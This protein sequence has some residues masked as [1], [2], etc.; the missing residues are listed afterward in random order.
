VASLILPDINLLVY[1]HNVDD[2]AFSRT[3]RWLSDLLSGRDRACFSWETI[4]GFV[5]LVTSPVVVKPTLS[6]QQ[7]FS[8]VNIWL[9]APGSVIL[10]KTPR[11]FA[12]LEEVAI[13]ANAAGRRFSDAVLA[14]IAI[15]N[16]VTLATAD[17][18]FKR[19]EGLK[20]VNP[21]ES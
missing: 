14:A 9:E 1:A 13:Q 16:N 2:P 5:R 20:W 11:H 19:F 3:N 15:E 18:D 6:L 4:N 17:S 7:A 21:L 12:V 8:A 10:K